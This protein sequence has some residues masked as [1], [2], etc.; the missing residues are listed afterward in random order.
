MTNSRL[1]FFRCVNGHLKGKT[2]ILIT[3]QLQFLKRADKILIMNEGESIAFGTFAQL[4]SIGI[5]FIKFLK[6]S[7][8]ESNNEKSE[9]ML[10]IDELYGLPAPPKLVKTLSRALTQVNSLQLIDPMDELTI[11]E[12][13]IEQREEKIS[14]GSLK[15]RVYL[16]YLLA[17]GNFVFICIFLITSF[18]SQGII[19][20]VD[21][22][23][24]DWSDESLLL[25]QSYQNQ[26]NNETLEGISF[27]EYS[28]P[29]VVKNTLIY[30]GLII[31]LLVGVLIRLGMNYRICLK[32]SETLHNRI[33]SKL[34]RT[35]LSFFENNPV[36]KGIQLVTF[37]HLII[38][39]IP[40]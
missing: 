26:N 22:W 3:H 33:F 13:Q 23:L 40:I 31:S 17:G 5:D 14:F 24:S 35:P 16:D 21:L 29:F 28:K 11:I 10:S 20:Y 6:E 34:L 4:N 7:E 25:S 18:A 2:R 9:E 27:S 39:L 15:G 36:G 8:A 38:Y 19:N 32:A 30:F 1:F 12:K 37:V